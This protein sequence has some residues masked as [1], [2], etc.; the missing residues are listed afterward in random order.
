MKLA[1]KIFIN[2][3][4]RSLNVLF[5]FLVIFAANFYISMTIFKSIET[6]EKNLKLFF[7]NVFSNFNTDYKKQGFK[8]ICC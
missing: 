3:F 5:L 6:A 7:L 4:E 2:L 8:H 1:I